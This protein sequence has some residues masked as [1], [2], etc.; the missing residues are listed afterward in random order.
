MNQ[1]Y[2]F[3][4]ILLAPVFFQPAWALSQDDLLPAEQAFAISSKIEDSSVILSWDIADGYYLYRDKFSFKINNADASL[5]AIEFPLGKV[6]HDPYFGSVEIYRKHVNIKIPVST[7]STEPFV[8]SIK[9]QGCADVGV[10]Y[11]PVKTKLDINPGDF[12]SASYKQ[13]VFD[14]S[15]SL[16]LAEQDQI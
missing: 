9:T 1:I 14:S 7:E 16:P 6:K 5:G 13:T 15:N 12:N 11:P 8:L 3:L 10:C 2:R 4:L